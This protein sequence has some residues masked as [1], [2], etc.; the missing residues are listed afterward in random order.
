MILFVTTPGHEYTLAPLVTNRFGVPIPRF[1]VTN[2]DRLLHR[3]QLP[4]ATYI[5]IDIERLTAW[6]QELAADLYRMLAAAGM[7]C[8]NNPA[9]VMHRFE[10]LRSLHRAGFNP[11]NVHLAND[12][13]RPA[14]FP[15]F[16]RRVF[17]HDGPTSDLIPDQAALVAQLRSLRERGMPLGNLLVVEWCAEEIAPGCWRKFGTMRVGD[18]MHVDHANV[19]AHWMIKSSTKG[20]ATEAMFEEERSAVASNRFAAALKPAFDLAGIDFGRADHAR[21]GGREV[22]YEINT[23][24]S[25]PEPAPQPSPTREAAKAIARARLAELFFAID[26]PEGP[27]V[28]IKATQRVRYEREKNGDRRWFMRP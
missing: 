25:F 18:A 4:R 9:R 20:L 3:D 15:V 8:L 19:A 11:Y 26:T 28:A 23:N 5:F 2:Y 16:L 27:P 14:R 6:E 10:L 17:D 22:V 1:E 21:V 12:E 7:R 13:P 24:P